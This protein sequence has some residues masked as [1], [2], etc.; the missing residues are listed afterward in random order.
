MGVAQVQ[1]LRFCQLNRINPLIVLELRYEACGLET[2]Q[3]GIVIH[4][5]DDGLIG[6]LVGQEGDYTAF[7]CPGI[8]LA[9][10]AT[11]DSYIHNATLNANCDSQPF[12]NRG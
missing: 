6:S 4:R 8:L 5:Q 12:K 2:P 1:M 3:S 10:G 7:T 11:I 9:T